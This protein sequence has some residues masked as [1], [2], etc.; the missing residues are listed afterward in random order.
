M[1]LHL[2]ADDVE[3]EVSRLEALGATRWDH[4]DERGFEFWVLRDP[5]AMNS[6]C[7]SRSSPSSWPGNSRG[8][9]VAVDQTAR[10]TDKEHTQ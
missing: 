1:H 8:I 7:S 3:A 10:I 6:A 5:G 9:P 4:Q 2:E